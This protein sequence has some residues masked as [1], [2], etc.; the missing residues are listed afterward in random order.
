M[1]FND[2]ILGLGEALL[3]DGDPENDPVCRDEDES[4]AML[5]EQNVINTREES[6]EL[7]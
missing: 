7:E 1:V 3:I 5:T 2:E 4:V 6:K